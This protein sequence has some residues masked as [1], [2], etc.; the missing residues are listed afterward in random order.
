MKPPLKVIKAWI[1]LCSAVATPWRLFE[2]DVKVVVIVET[3]PIIKI[4][5]NFGDKLYHSAV[6][7]R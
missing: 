4:T 6:T 7:P 5:S 3:L 2:S 1:S